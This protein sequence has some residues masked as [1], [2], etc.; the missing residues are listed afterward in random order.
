MVLATGDVAPTP[1]RDRQAALGDLRRRVAIQSSVDA[2]DGVRARRILFALGE[3]PADLL[4]ALDALDRFERAIVE[5][6]DP[7]VI[8]ARRLN[9][10]AVLDRLAANGQPR[11]SC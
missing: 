6:D 11:A 5:C 2:A 4:A 10:L 9:C 3:P 1:W 7:S 8:E